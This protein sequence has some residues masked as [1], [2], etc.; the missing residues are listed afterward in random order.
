MNNLEHPFKKELEALRNIIK[1]SNPKIC[2]RIKWNAPSYYYGKYDF[3]AFNLR[4]TK[5][6]HLV[7]VFPSGIVK[8]ET[9]LLEGEYKDRRM[10]YFYSMEDIEKKK[11]ALENI[12]NK[13]IDSVHEKIEQDVM[14]NINKDDY[15]H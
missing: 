13:W 11:V 14:N 10:V 4:E 6:V 3:G 15:C 9:G 2:E 8:D 7:L 12:V 1:S 5:K